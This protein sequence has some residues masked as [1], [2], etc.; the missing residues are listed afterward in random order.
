MYWCF[1][2]NSPKYYPH[3]TFPFLPCP[4][5]HTSKG[6]DVYWEVTRHKENAALSAFYYTSKL[7]LANVLSA[8]ASSLLIFSWESFCD[9]QPFILST[10][11]HWGIKPT[12]VNVNTCGEVSDGS[13]LSMVEVS[14]MWNLKIQELAL[15]GASFCFISQLHSVQLLLLNGISQYSI[16]IIFYPDVQQHHS[17]LNK[18]KNIFGKELR[19]LKTYTGDKFALI[20]LLK[21]KYPFSQT[22]SGQH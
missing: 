3:N 22:R 17:F 9:M 6:R 18:K 13:D 20:L 5:T 15:Q 12:L 11:N 2:G 16:F 10:I 8:P 21:I 7:A 14:K 19:S 4:R 1:Q